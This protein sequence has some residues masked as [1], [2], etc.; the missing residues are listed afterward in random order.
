MTSLR[1]S[2]LSTRDAWTILLLAAGLAASSAA[3]AAAP[4]AGKS[5]ATYANIRYGYT[6]EY[7][8]DRL[9]PG[10]EADDG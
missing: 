4:P 3:Y 8:K 2:P 1:L 10:E 9:V 6:I 7:P 5:L